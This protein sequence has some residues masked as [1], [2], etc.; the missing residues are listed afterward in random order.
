MSHAFLDIAFTPAVKAC[1]IEHGSRAGYARMEEGPA[2]ND[3]L[4]PDERDFI[5]ARDSLYMATVSETG[6]PYIQHR[7]GPEGF[8]KVLDDKTLAFAD[9]RGNRQ[10]V[11]VG[12][13]KGDDRVSLFLM[14]YPNRTRLKL[15]GRA[16]TRDLAADPELAA[17]LALPGYQGRPE[18][19][20]LIHVEGF[21][22]NC[23]QHITPR[24][25]A[26]QVRE[27]VKPLHDRIAALEAALAKAGVKVPT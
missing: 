9:F 23:P 20:I 24:Y 22:W 27:A 1:Q 11:T 6:W 17:A 7:G 2:R 12:N 16:E 14:D 5:A 26:E 25:T 15:L 3:R 4:G 13:L 10:Y 8:I 21:D 19:A 18:R